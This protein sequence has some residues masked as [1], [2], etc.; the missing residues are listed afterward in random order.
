MQDWSVKIGIVEYLNAWPFRLPLES[1]TK[2][3]P[4]QYP[5]IELIP[6]IP[7]HLAQ[8]LL[9]NN[10]DIALIS[11][12]EYWRNRDKLSY[13]ADWCIAADSEVQS[14]R[15]TVSEKNIEV[16][17]INALENIDRIYCDKATRSSQA[18][19]LLLYNELGL[20]KPEIVF[21]DTQKQVPDYRGLSGQEGFLAIGDVALGQRQS[22]SFDLGLEYNDIFGRSFVYALWCFSNAK[23]SKEKIQMANLLRLAMINSDSNEKIFEKATQKYAYS[24]EFIRYYLTDLIRYEL[25][26]NLIH[27]M[28]F[29]FENA[30]PEIINLHKQLS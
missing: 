13:L 16:G 3:P 22:P 6:G 29:F 4:P 23:S 7:S 14:I 28:N 25:T 30:P 17:F 20:R 1:F 15:L 27:D 19:L 9:H 21:I 8:E 18:M 26:E 12:I 11:S 5:F 2:N 24:K 10:L